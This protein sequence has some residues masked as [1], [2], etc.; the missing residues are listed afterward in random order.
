[1]EFPEDWRFAAPC[2]RIGL[3]QILQFNKRQLPLFNSRPGA[4]EQRLREKCDVPFEL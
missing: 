2:S 3:E 4:E 1:L